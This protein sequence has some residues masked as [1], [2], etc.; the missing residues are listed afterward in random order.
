MFKIILMGMWQW[1]RNLAEC[2][3][4]VPDLGVGQSH[5]RGSGQTWSHMQDW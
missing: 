4:A 2:K 5:R 3:K 1:Y